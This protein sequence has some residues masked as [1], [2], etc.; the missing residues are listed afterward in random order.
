MS[1]PSSFFRPLQWRKEVPSHDTPTA[2]SSSPPPPI[3]RGTV[4]GGLTRADLARIGYEFTR[5]RALQ[6]IALFKLT[7]ER[8][9]RQQAEA[10]YEGCMAA[11]EPFPFQPWDVRAA[12]L[13]HLRGELNDEAK[14]TT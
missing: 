14:E 3:T 12:I 5:E 1:D 4:G 11:G 6:Y 8:F 10:H 2:Q 13:A 9:A 7:P